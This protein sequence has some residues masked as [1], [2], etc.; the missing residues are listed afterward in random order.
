MLTMNALPSVDEVAA[1]DFRKSVALAPTV[2]AALEAD[3]ADVE[4]VL[5][6]ML[7][8]SDGIRGFF[9]QYL[10][11]A[12]LSKPDAPEPPAALMKAMASAPAEVLAELM[13]MNVVMPTAT[14]LLHVRNNDIGMAESSRLTARRATA[15]V[16]ALRP[17]AALI[18]LRCLLAVCDNTAAA[19]GIGATVPTERLEFWRQFCD[20]W[21]YDE[22][23]RDLV[24]NVA[25]ALVEAWED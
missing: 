24:A 5:A 23:Q 4:P 22:V 16:S 21:Q 2:C 13:V 11:D 7:K 14:S 19:A 17:P 15:V 9:V 25:G 6:A 20:R 10:T 12:E 8:S 3:N 18:D 1:A